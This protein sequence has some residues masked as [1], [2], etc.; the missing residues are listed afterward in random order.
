M[1]K[2]HTAVI[3]FRKPL[4]TLAAIRSHRP[5]FLP[6]CGLRQLKKSGYTQR[7]RA[8]LR[9]ARKPSK[10]TWC[11]QQD[12]RKIQ[13]G[14]PQGWPFYAH[15]GHTLNATHDLDPLSLP[16]TQERGRGES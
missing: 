16:R 12:H 5:I 4:S 11:E 3:D 10:S 1:N 6:K 8:R 13:Q 14:Y 2:H 9:E 7:L 15:R